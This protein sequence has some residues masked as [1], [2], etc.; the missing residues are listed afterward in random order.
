MPGAGSLHT[1]SLGTQDLSEASW[2][3]DNGFEGHRCKLRNSSLRQDL[4]SM[5]H[6]WLQGRQTRRGLQR[7]SKREVGMGVGGDRQWCH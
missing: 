2:I 4:R 7:E 1:L 6:R 3:S 5:D